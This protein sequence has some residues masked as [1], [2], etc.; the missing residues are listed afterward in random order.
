[1]VNKSKKT[2]NTNKTNKNLA[3][4]ICTIIGVVA[5]IVIIITVIL[6]NRGASLNDSFFVSDD[7]KYVLTLDTD[8]V[9]MEDPEYNPIKTH[10]VYSYSG[11]EITGMKA[12]YEYS[13]SAAAKSALEYLKTNY[14]DENQD[15]ITTNGKY[16]IFTAS[17]AE[18]ENLTANDVKEQIDFMEML[19]NINTEN[20]DE[21][22]T[23]D[24]SEEIIVESTAE[25]QST[26]KKYDT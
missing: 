1:M 9:S 11:E 15:K 24:T 6:L 14:E 25:E 16:V 8:S 18:Y 5:I 13:D 26:T 2:N 17:E 21:E 4:G 7:T 20:L 3:L 12:Y 10:I 19:K 22:S 23:S